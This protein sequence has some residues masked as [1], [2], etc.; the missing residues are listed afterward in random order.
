MN[1]GR[2][3]QKGRKIQEAGRQVSAS[4]QVSRD[5]RG[6]RQAGRAEQRGMEAGQVRQAGRQV[7][8]QNWA[9]KAGM[10]SSGD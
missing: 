2:A 9:Q 6:G 10:Q 4:I 5:G 7:S 8:R 3:Y 1:V